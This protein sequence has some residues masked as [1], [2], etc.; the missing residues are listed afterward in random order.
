MAKVNDLLS[1]LKRNNVQLASTLD[2]QVLDLGLNTQ[3][4]LEPESTVKQ[5][6]NLRRVGYDNAKEQMDKWL[7]IVKLN[8]EKEHLNFTER[9]NSNVRVN[10]FP[11]N[12]NNPLSDRIEK[13]LAELNMASQKQLITTEEKQLERLDPE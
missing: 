3:N 13:E 9:S 4:V 10:F 8:R 11:S 7:P 6:R 2:R 12:Q 1:S 5:E